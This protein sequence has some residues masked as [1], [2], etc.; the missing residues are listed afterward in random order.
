MKASTRS[1]L[2]TCAMLGFSLLLVPSAVHADLVWGLQ[3]EGG[4]VRIP[5]CRDGLNNND[6]DD[7]VDWPD[8]AECDS[9][10]DN[11]E[12]I[13]GVQP[14][15]TNIPDCSDRLDNDRDGHVDWP[16]D[17]ECES[18]DDN[19]ERKPGFQ[20][21]FTCHETII[22]VNFP[23]GFP[24][25]EPEFCPAGCY[26]IELIDFR[27]LLDASLSQ[28]WAPSENWKGSTPLKLAV[29]VPGIE[30]DPGIPNLR[31]QYVGQDEIIGPAVVGK[32]TLRE[33][34][35]FP[36]GL[37]YVGQAFDTQAGRVVINTGTLS[38][39]AHPGRD[40]LFDA[41]LSYSNWDPG[42]GVGSLEGFDVELCPPW[43]PWPWPRR[44]RVDLRISSYEIDKVGFSRVIPLEL[45]F[46]LPFSSA[47][48]VTPYVGA[49]LGYYLINGD[50]A[51]AQN[52]LGGY[53]ALGLD[54][55]LGDRWGLSFEGAYREVG[56]SLGF[57][58]P[59]FEAGIGFNF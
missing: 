32:I 3:C 20:E 13:S 16:D 45:G 44:P 12:S 46:L 41:K 14:P 53:G 24:L 39:T 15:P 55:H 37:K 35:G 23:Q 26:W 1:S 48:R 51:A 38:A 18:S 34:F 50:S 59:V 52:E 31:L 56:G 2:S 9:S 7:A 4:P 5:E 42:A 54:I 36:A 57:G 33:P 17:V 58:G 6:G 49:G 27:A 11:N 21:S 25:P 28:I 40:N 10:D 30:D 43:W 29:P 19:N 47:S 22:R 8:D